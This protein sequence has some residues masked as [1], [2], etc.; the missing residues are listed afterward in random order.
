MSLQDNITQNHNN[1]SGDRLTDVIKQAIET[2]GLYK[3]PL[4]IDFLK[5]NKPD[6]EE[7][8]NANSANDSGE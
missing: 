2:D 1:K 3:G 7:N 5:N 6:A 8:A 4:D